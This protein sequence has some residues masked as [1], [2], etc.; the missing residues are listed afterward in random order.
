[1]IGY[2]IIINSNTMLNVTNLISNVKETGS[3]FSAGSFLRLSGDCL[4][5]SL[6]LPGEESSV[7]RAIEDKSAQENTS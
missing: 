7:S 4:L 6:P 1:M 3:G 5:L 2:I